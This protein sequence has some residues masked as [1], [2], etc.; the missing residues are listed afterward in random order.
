MGTNTN[1]KTNTSNKHNTNNKTSNKTNNKTDNKTNCSKRRTNLPN[2]PT[3]HGNR[4]S[5]SELG[6]W[7]SCWH[8]GGCGSDCSDSHCHGSSYQ[9]EHHHDALSTGCFYKS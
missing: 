5:Y 9:K 1:N 7:N 6:L 3:P 4:S 2:S 8:S